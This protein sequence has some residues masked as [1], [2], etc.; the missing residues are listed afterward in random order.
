[1]FSETAQYAEAYEKCEAVMAVHAGK[2]LAVM[3]LL[4]TPVPALYDTLCEGFK[5]WPNK[6][7]APFYGVKALEAKRPDMAAVFEKAE[8]WPLVWKEGAGVRFAYV[9][10]LELVSDNATYRFDWVFI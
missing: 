10:S 9:P 3:P 7:A 8:A 6:Y 2:N 4:N 1:V 5:S